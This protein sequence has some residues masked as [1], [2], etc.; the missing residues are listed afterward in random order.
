MRYSYQFKNNISQ[1]NTTVESVKEKVE[2]YGADTLSVQDCLTVLLG[3]GDYCFDDLT[4][5]ELETYI[6][7]GSLSKTKRLKLQAL[8]SLTKH[9]NTKTKKMDSILS[10]SNFVSIVGEDIKHLNQE[11]FL[12]AFLDTKNQVIDIKEVFKGTLNRSIV[13][14]REVFA[15]A[16]KRH[17]ASIIVAHNHPSG[18]PTPSQADIQITERL[19]EA[20]EI[21]GI[22]LIDHVIIGGE[23]FVSLKEKGYV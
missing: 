16:I 14:P 11:V 6:D 4:L 21:I 13:H 9:L 5:S 23:D 17:S 19:Y 12:V 7:S 3:K 10:P 22:K 2:T 18:D 8:V 15:E 1:V 20:G